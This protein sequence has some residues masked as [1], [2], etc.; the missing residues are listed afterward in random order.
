MTDPL[1]PCAAPGCS[2]PRRL[3]SK[4]CSDNCCQ[5]VARE[6]RKQRIAAGEIKPKPR[7]PQ[8]KRVAP[9]RPAVE[10]HDPLC[11]LPYYVTRKE[12]ETW[13]QQHAYPRG[14]LVWVDGMEVRV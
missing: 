12:H 5:R 6:R 4:Y 11:S 7:K 2:K 9:K 3:A 1:P 10:V 13:M 8:P 14:T